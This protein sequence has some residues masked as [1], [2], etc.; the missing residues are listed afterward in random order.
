MKLLQPSS[1]E[2]H[3]ETLRHL[4]QGC[5]VVQGNLE[6][7]YLPPGADTAFLKVRGFGDA[8][9]REGRGVPGVSPPFCPISPS[10]QDIKEV[11][12]YVLIAENHVSAVGLQGLRIIR[13]T[14]LFQERYALAVLGN[15]GLR[16]LGMRQLTGRGRK[17]GGGDGWGVAAWELQV[18]E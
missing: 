2:S 16:Q 9:H 5:Q 4:Y 15:V 11:Q 7:T 18:H 12:G 17:G 8:W 1:P 3:Y 13:G 6:L 14:Q 10:P